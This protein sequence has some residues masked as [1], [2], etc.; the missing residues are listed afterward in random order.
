MFKVGDKLRVVDK[1][2]VF[3]GNECLVDGGITTVERVLNERGDFA[4]TDMIRGGA[5]LGIAIQQAGAA[6]VKIESETQIEG[7]PKL[8]KKVAVAKVDSEGTEVHGAQKFSKGDEFRVI[9][10]KSPQNFGEFVVANALTEGG[11]LDKA[12]VVEF[13]E[14]LIVFFNE[15]SEKAWHIDD[16]FE[17]KEVA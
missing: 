3:F 4:V 7:E 16:Y 17:I 14:G 10:L 8:T 13:E 1:T 12:V 15:V 2:K 5:P 6:F 11:D 9:D